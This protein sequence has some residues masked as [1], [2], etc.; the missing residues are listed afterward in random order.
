MQGFDVFGDEGDGDD[1]HLFYAFV[2]EFVEGADEGGLEPFG[3]ADFALEAEEMRARPVGEFLRS[4]FA[5]EAH[6][7]LNVARVRIAIFNQAHWQAVR[8][9][10]EMN[11]RAVR[12]L[13]QAFANVGDQRLDVQRV[14][15]EMFDGAF[16]ERVHRLAINAAPLL[17]AAK[18]GGGG[19][20]R[21]KGQKNEFI[22]PVGFFDGR[23]GVLR[24]RLPV[25][26]RGDRDWFHVR[27]D[28][29]DEFGA[30]AFG[31]DADGRAASDLAVALGDGRSALFS[32]VA[33]QRAADE[34]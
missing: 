30:L 23:N 26:H 21:V 5:D 19:I 13:S 7:L 27:V 28:G 14:I 34:I 11:A 17:Q 24:K 10:D 4:A 16:G 22:E 1:E 9:E 15:E 3:R 32:D 20:M 33:G 31:E 18:G 29:R 25:A 2:A 12:K 6:G 8:A